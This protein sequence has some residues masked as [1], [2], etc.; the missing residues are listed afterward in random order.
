MTRFSDLPNHEQMPRDESGRMMRVDD[1]TTIGTVNSEWEFTESLCT[2]NLNRYKR[3]VQEF[4][5]YAKR[6]PAGERVAIYRELLTDINKINDSA[7]YYS[8]DL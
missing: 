5:A 6:L 7:V 8:E 3:S 1:N 2:E 4:I